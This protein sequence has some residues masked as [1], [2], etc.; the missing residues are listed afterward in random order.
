M[1]QMEQGGHSLKMSW[2]RAH[3]LRKAGWRPLCS[4]GSSR[5]KQQDQCHRKARGLENSPHAQL[6]SD[7][8]QQPTHSSKRSLHQLIHSEGH[9]S[10]T[11]HPPLYSF[12]IWAP[13]STCCAVLM[14]NQPPA[15]HVKG[16]EPVARLQVLSLVTHLGGEFS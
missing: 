7:S 12:L 6:A 2:R 1:S 10:P 14:T 9:M 11:K 13:P 8:L 5:N 3:F 16:W 15:L 4:E